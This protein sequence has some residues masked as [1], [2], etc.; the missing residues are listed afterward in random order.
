MDTEALN[1]GPESPAVGATGV[2]VRPVFQWTAVISA[3][4]YELLVAT[5]AGLTEPVI[6]LTGAQAP[7][8]N[9]WQC[10]VNLEYATTYY[11][12]VKAVNASTS[13]AWSTTGLFTTEAAPSG[14]V[15]G[16]TPPAEPENTPPDIQLPPGATATV[17][18]AAPSVNS[19]DAAGTPGTYY[20]VPDWVIYFIGG[21]LAAVILAL[22]VVL[23]IVLKIKHVP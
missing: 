11:W 9:V 21:L 3:T 8:G 14:D 22:S 13:S 5:D 16:M 6:N 18:I 10:D 15:A 19:T 23:V 20:S 4:S 17:T 12:K 7:A 2:P 1:I